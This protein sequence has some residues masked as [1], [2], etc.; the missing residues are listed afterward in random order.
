MTYLSD[1]VLDGALNI[2]N[3]NA[4]RIDICS[5]EPA[6]Y[7]EATSTYTLGFKDHGAA[8]SAFGNPADRSPSGRKVSSTAVTDGAVTAT[9]TATHYA[10]SDTAN[11]A[12]LAAAALSASQDVT[13]GNVFTLPSFDIGI[14]DPS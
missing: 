4:D 8:G 10:V 12:L 13:S 9:D 2:L 5:Q 7:T 6:T 14:P 3:N 11:T 1:T